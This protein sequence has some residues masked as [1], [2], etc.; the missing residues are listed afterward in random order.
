[1]EGAEKRISELE[2]RTIQITQSEKQRENRLAGR[3]VA[4]GEEKKS[5]S[6]N[7]ETIAKDQMLLLLDLGKRGE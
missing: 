7:C 2:N 1:M 5:S 4:G 6:G 3:G